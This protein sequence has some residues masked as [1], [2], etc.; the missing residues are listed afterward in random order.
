M[1]DSHVEDT[2][3]G[4]PSIGAA[5]VDG[6]DFET[7]VGDPA[8]YYPAPEAIVADDE[9]TRAQKRRFLTEWAQDLCQRQVASDEGMAVAGRCG[10][11]LDAD[12][13]LAA[14]TDTEADLIKR[15]QAALQ[16]LDNA[17]DIDAF[18]STEHP[19]KLRWPPHARAA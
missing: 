7:A 17:Q 18:P 3:S 2:A 10:D 1:T 16:D 9:Q 12:A 8:G 14:P 11:D 6:V 13:H 5:G 15:I 4:D 19:G